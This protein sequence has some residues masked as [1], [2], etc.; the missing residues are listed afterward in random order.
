MA[1]S[2]SQKEIAAFIIG[3]GITDFV[4][5]GRLSLIERNA[6]WKVL[7]K[8]GPPT[9]TTTGRIA[10]TA[11][12]GIARAAPAIARTG[13][14][15]TRLIA[16]RHPYIT[17]AV[18]TYE[19]VKNREQIA[20]LLG[21][22]WEIV[23]DTGGAAGAMGSIIQERIEERGLIQPLTRLPGL[24]RRKTAYN[25]AISAGMKAIKRSNKMGPKGKFTNSKRAFA[26]VSKTAS[27][28]RKGAKVALGHT[29]IGIAAR[30][31]KGILRRKK[32]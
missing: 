5:G 7:K 29:P 9:V 12:M 2:P 21:E 25:R 11:A 3:H 27:R 22:G 32:K 18:V 1:R 10:G 28:L 31:M 30:A 19:A 26:L 15:A 6:L 20:Q 17:A 24:K 23:Q 8:L 16:M 13:L 4:T 14:Q